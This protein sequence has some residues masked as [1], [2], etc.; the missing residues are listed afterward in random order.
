MSDT[1]TCTL[2][3]ASITNLLN[4]V[5]FAVSWMLTRVF[6]SSSSSS[7]FY[8][9]LPY[10]N[11]RIAT[12]RVDSISILFLNCWSPFSL[13][14]PRLADDNIK[15]L[16]WYYI[17][18]ANCC[19]NCIADAAILVSSNEATVVWSHTFG[20]AN[21]IRRRRREISLSSF[22]VA[23]RRTTTTTAAAAAVSFSVAMRW[24]KK[25]LDSDAIWLAHGGG[26]GRG[27]AGAPCVSSDFLFFSFS[28]LPS[29]ILFHF[30]LFF[31]VAF[32]APHR[33]SFS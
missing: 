25:V 3:Q 32:D 14:S 5:G 30:I 4:F 12:M 20:N 18:Q 33:H 7:S 1:K 15:T 27:G 13:T 19:L 23:S 16:G 2:I 31:L 26:S 24:E 22:L 29:F 17:V 10:R 11:N 21:N 6:P 28:F 9:F 8:M